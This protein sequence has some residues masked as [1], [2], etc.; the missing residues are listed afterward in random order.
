MGLKTP[1][2]IGKLQRTL[3]TKAKEQMA[4]FSS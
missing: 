2:K 1:E 3:Y 4:R